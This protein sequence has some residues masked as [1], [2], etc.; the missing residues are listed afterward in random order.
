MGTLHHDDNQRRRKHIA[1]IR[2]CE[3]DDVPICDGESCCRSGTSEIGSEIFDHAHRAEKVNQNADTKSPQRSQCETDSDEEDKEEEIK[4]LLVIGA[5]PH[6]LTLML[7][8][9][10]PDPDLITDSDRHSKAE[11]K[12][13]MR[14]MHD[15][16]RHVKNLSRGPG[17]ILK[18]RKSKIKDQMEKNSSRT[19]KKISKKRKNEI[20]KNLFRPPAPPALQLQEVH[21]SVMVVDSHGDW[22]TSWKQNFNTIGIK[23]LR[24]LM[25]AHADPYDHRALEYY[26]E[27]YGR[28]DELV[29]LKDLTQRDK[30]FKGPYQAPSTSLF[31][32]FHDLLI[33]G[34]GIDNIVQ[35]GTVES[36]T[37]EPS[38][39]DADEPVFEV[40]FNNADSGV[41]AVKTKRVVCAMGPNFS[42]NKASWWDDFLHEHSN[43]KYPR[44]KILQ[45]NEIVP[46]IRERATTSTT[47]QQDQDLRLLIVGGGITSAQLTLLASKASWCRG[48]T[49]IQRSK[50]LSRHFDVENKWMGPNRGKL[51][52]DF[53]SLD[54]ESRPAKLREARGGGSM[55]PELLREIYNQVEE[56]DLDSFCVREE[57][58]ISHVKWN[59]ER[60]DVA[61]DDGSE[62]EQYDMIWLVTGS[63]NNLDKYA[64]FDD[65]R[66]TLPVETVNGL[67][68]LNQDLSWPSRRRGGTET[69]SESQV[70][71]EYAGE[72]R[73]AMSHTNNTNDEE[74]WKQIARRRF[75]CMGVLASLELGP[76]ALNLVGAR[77][78]AVRVATAIRQDMAE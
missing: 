5:G 16:F 25:N 55:P 29:T 47:K 44:D 77:Q 14:S 4:E 70:K 53:W 19:Q 42:S 38:Q 40:R 17:T 12:Q 23:R 20:N 58:E 71:T 22:L 46:W 52:A 28:D 61:F 76:D 9:L 54:M 3:N 69:R 73:D 64:A 45:A 30:T 39:T 21:K 41:M 33:K 50:T 11:F 63:E 18:T 24:S 49:L 35:Q 6:S 51:L 15:V 62:I 31:N 74:K 2:K 43:T 48:V 7:R 78:G 68:V 66:E 56:Q 72:N 67:P 13:R 27:K 60:F 37:P 57:V 26:A 34:Y 59:G 36:I 32:D 10:E 75:W 8:L 1:S 65:L